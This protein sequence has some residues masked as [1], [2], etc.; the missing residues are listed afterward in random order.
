MKF[1]H[2][3]DK[4][5]PFQNPPNHVRHYIQFQNSGALMLFLK[6]FQLWSLVSLQ[7]TQCMHQFYVVLLFPNVNHYFFSLTQR[8]VILLSIIRNLKTLIFSIK[9]VTFLKDNGVNWTWQT[10]NTIF[11]SFKLVSPSNSLCLL[12]IFF[13]CR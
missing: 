6:F 9:R 1:Y 3:S 11:F 2:N 12:S 4:R 8:Y 10:E 5:L 7:N 13:A